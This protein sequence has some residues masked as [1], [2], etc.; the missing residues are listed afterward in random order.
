MCQYS[1]REGFA[2][3]WHL[4]HLGAFAVGGAALVLTEATAV[5]P[6]GR[7]SPQDL[8]IWDDAHIPMLRRINRF[9]HEQGAASGVQLAHAGRKSSTRR[10]WEGGGRIAPAEGGW[11]EVLAPSAI[12]FADDYPQPIALTTAG[13]GAVINAFRDA[14]RR[15]LQ[16]EFQ[17]V[18]IH[19]AHGYLLHE[20]LSPLSNQRTDE[21]GGSFE[22]RIRLTLDVVRAIRS[23][24][25]ESA[26]LFVRLSATDWSPGGWE[27]EQ[28]VQ[29]A[30]RLAGEGVDLIDC[31][32]GGLVA[33]ATIPLS[34]GY[35]VPF[36]RR[37]RQDGGIATGAVGL[38]TAPTQAEA[39]VTSG[40]ADLVLMARELLRSPRWPLEAARA[41]GV[42][43]PWPPQ[44]ERARP[45]EPVVR[46]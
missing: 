38:I 13:I 2:S 22:N 9:V 20:F 18:E 16:A 12:P 8:G 37:M 25:P 26:P 21:Y 41:L 27:I 5:T 17:V 44:Y 19:A 42:S 11:N 33:G 7:I 28:S 29:L 4:V 46:L 40:D 6:E 10:P 1:S 31:S 39:I 24:W 15:A 14:A 43:I 23:I 30:Q 36:A 32:S 45:R 34:P 3:D 35:Q